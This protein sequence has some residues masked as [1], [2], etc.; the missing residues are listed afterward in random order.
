MTHCADSSRYNINHHSQ[1]SGSSKTLCERLERNIEGPNAFAKGRFPKYNR[2]GG[3]S[4]ES[5]PGVGSC[6]IRHT[7]PDVRHRSPNARHHNIV[8]TEVVE[9]CL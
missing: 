6:N 3:I 1:R 4:L 9:Y 8:E 2:S 5:V 7:R